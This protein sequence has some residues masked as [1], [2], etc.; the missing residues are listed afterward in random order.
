[1][2][3]LQAQLEKFQPRRVYLDKDRGAEIFIRSIG[4]SY[5]TIQPGIKTG[6][7][8]FQL[9]DTEINRAFLLDLIGFML[10]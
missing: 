4:G 8:P 1:M 2:T 5:A 3:F 6:F 7:N 10:K 9:P